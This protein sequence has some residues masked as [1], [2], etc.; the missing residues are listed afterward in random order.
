MRWWKLT[1]VAV[2]AGGIAALAPGRR[3]ERDA[4][5]VPRGPEPSRAEAS[6]VIEEAGLESFP[7]SDPPPWTL[8]ADR[9]WG[10]AL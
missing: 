1:F 3:G 10:D 2:A 8:D 4:G 6:R 5:D 7:A 9:L